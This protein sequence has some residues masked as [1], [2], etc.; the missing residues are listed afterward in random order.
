M[1]TGAPGAWVRGAAA[2]ALGLLLSACASERVQGVAAQPLPAPAPPE[3]SGPC[4]FALHTLQDRRSQADLG[5][6]V[7][8]QV[9]GSGFVEWLEQGL[10]ALPEHRA[11][12]TSQTLRVE[13]LKAHIESL[14]TLKSAHLVVRVE[15]TLAGGRKTQR[16]YRGADNSVN[17]NN[18][19]AEIQE[20]FG[21]GLAGPAA[22][23]QRRPGPR[24]PGGLSLR[25]LGC[26]P[27][28]PTRARRGARGTESAMRFRSAA[29][30]GLV[31]LLVGAQAQAGGPVKAKPGSRTLT[32]PAWACS[33]APGA[34]ARQQQV[35]RDLLPRVVFSG[36]TRPASLAERMARHQVPA[37]SVA[38]IR[39]GRLDWS[40]SWGVQAAGAAAVDCDS[41][42]QA[43]SLAKPVTVLAALRMK[44][45]GRLDFDLPIERYLSSYRLPE[46]KQSPEQ[47][48][49]LR[50][51]FSHTAGLTPGGYAGYAQGQALPNELQIL[52]A[53]PPSNSPKLEVLA[54]PG[55]ALRYSGGGYT[56]AQL[57]LQDHFNQPFEPLM[58]AWILGPAGMQGADFTQPLPP[59]QHARVARGHAAD[60]RAVP[61]GW[62]NHPE[63]AA[64]GLWATPSDLAALLIELRRAWLGQSK[65][66]TRESIEELLAQP[67]EG[68]AYGFRLMGEG[69]QRF[70]VHYGGTAGYNA[71]MTLNLQ[72]G[73]GAVYMANSENG[74]AL[75]PEFLGAVA[76]G[77]GWPVFR[78]LQVTRVP[79]P[80]AVLQSLAGAYAFAAQGWQVS[81]L[82][83]H[84]ALTLVFPNGDRYAMAPIEGEPLDFIHPDTAVR[85]RFQ[86][87]GG[88]LRLK[89]YGQTGV[90]REPAG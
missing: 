16:I 11:G 14:A 39:A 70:L 74:Y 62:H 36:E 87:E 7:R 38:V 32:Q 29:A 90:R 27:R 89:L 8:T 79:Q 67:I 20:A 18:S 35:L 2:V 1:K 88:E 28:I 85:A 75:G 58:R 78:A 15:S 83:E 6:L 65:V 53:E 10:R 4:R 59:A 42:F 21:A 30:V 73:D 55:E 43:G 72:T 41:L 46:G 60:G 54:P 49:T 34:P 81:V 80:E 71:G 69:D 68:H 56:L 40:A 9:D 37:F 45:A 33:S 84:E 47:P 17:W 12:D 77:Y 25:P 76:R 24:L 22:S 3:T 48:V 5:L 82:Y 57:A 61:G 66:L 44:A 19:Q 64:A 52:R 13:V 50:H 51:L 31:C 26:G 23:A 63:Q 86:R